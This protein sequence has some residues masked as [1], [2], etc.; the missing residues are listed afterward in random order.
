MSVTIPPFPDPPPTRDDPENFAQR[1]DAVMLAFPAIVTAMNAQNVEN[2]ALNTNVNTKHAEALEAAG[3][4]SDAAGVATTQAGIALAQ[5]GI[6]TSAAEDA[7]DSAAA[8][9]TFVPANYVPRAGGITMTGHL[10]VP[11]GAAGNEVPRANEVFGKGQSWQTVTRTSGVTYT[12]STS[13][14]IIVVASATS[15]AVE[16]GLS[17]LVGSDIVSW[18]SWPETSTNININFIV[19]PGN[20]Y[21]IEVYNASALAVKEYR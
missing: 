10:S 19:P 18:S 21:K 6:A 5:A 20:T 14:P 8:A 7:A 3:D 13:K 4:A 15:S 9:A 2:N 12:N 11:A 17:G 1:A 16:N